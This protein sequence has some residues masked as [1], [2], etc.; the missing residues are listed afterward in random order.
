MS[1]PWDD[2]EKDGPWSDYRTT[3]LASVVPQAAPAPTSISEIGRQRESERTRLAGLTAR[4]FLEGAS[5][6]TAL[7][8]DAAVAAYNL[9]TGQN[10]R[11][12]SRAISESL[13][14]IGLPEPQGAAET[15]LT[16]TS[17]ALG[18]VPARL[19]NLLSPRLQNLPSGRVGQMTM[20]DLLVD[21]ARARGLK[22][23]PA[24]VRT[25]VGPQ[26][27]ESFGGKVAT[28]QT[29]SV[30]NQKIINRM[31]AEEIGLDPTKPISPSAVQ[32]VRRQAGNIYQKIKDNFRFTADDEYINDLANLDES[33]RVIQTDFPN[34]PMGDM[35]EIRETAAAIAEPNFSA[36]GAI[37]LIKRLRFQAS[38][39]LSFAVDDPAKKALGNAQIDAAE[40]L[41]ALMARNLRRLGRPELA[42]EFDESRR[43]IAKTYSI[44]QA[45]SPATGNVNARKLAQELQ[46]RKPL[47]GNLS[48]IARFAQ[49][50]PAASEDLR[51]SQAA[52]LE[53]YAAL[54]SIVGGAGFSSPSLALL[55]ASI[56]LARY[57]VRQ[58][59]MSEPVQRT[60]TPRPGTPTGGLLAPT[61]TGIQTNR[62]R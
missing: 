10:I 20:E 28:Q 52:A 8:L 55:G 24:T 50:F 22:I 62:Q 39:N 51:R 19:S 59:L 12:P 29:A 21:E 41:E 17:G 37:E 54:G 25:T 6:L 2:Y 53:G 9:A 36:K 27:A 30:Q 3:P 14:S 46:R 5:G 60:L 56:P 23:P 33:S 40:A 44:E 43:T 38:S 31:A 42:D 18:G 11:Q 32:E 61:V 48:L 15:G 34:L 58:T 47:S 7:P 45:M 26:I 1:G 49:A 16:I 35:K 13:T 57:G 4:G